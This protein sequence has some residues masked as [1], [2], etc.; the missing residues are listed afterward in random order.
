MKTHLKNKNS[1]EKT[2]ADTI[3]ARKENFADLTFKKYQK[4]WIYLI[5]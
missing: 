5:N 1:L 3:K 4:E 2:L